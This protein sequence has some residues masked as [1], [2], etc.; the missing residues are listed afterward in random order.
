MNKDEI[1]NELGK[2]NADDDI[3]LFKAIEVA[4]A[5][6]RLSKDT[7]IDYLCNAIPE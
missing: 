2:I 4:S 3:A 7:D 5:L 1:L 6:V